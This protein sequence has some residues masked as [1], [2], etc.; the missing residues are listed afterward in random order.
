MIH[1]NDERLQ[2]LLMGQERFLQE[3]HGILEEEQ[4]KDDVLRAVVRSGPHVD[5][6]NRIARLDPERVFHVASIR[7]LVHPLPPAIPGRRPLQGRTAA[8]RAL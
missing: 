5:G 4:K 1:A 6:I 3:V 2:R 7:R 8:A